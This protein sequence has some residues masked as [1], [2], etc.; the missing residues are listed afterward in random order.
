MKPRLA[1]KN[2]K[3]NKKNDELLE[4]KKIEIEKFWQKTE[5]I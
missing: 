5:K 3:K 4:T 1:E 2:Q